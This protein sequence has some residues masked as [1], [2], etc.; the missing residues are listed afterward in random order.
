[1]KVVRI[2]MGS[3][4]I[5]SVIAVVLAEDKKPVTAPAK[6]PAPK[7]TPAQ[8]EEQR[9][10]EKYDHMAKVAGLSDDQHSKLTKAITEHL[11]IKNAWKTENGPVLTKLNAARGGGYIFQSDHSVPGNVPGAS[12]DY[13]VKLVREYGKY[14]LEL[15]QFDIPE[16]A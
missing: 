12:Y 7:L 5:L 10:R 2:F 11:A 6:A 16:L 8:R 13:V 14:P 4:V 9:I 1:M 15:G 3:L